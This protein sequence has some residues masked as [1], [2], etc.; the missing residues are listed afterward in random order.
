LKGI[1]RDGNL[2]DSLLAVYKGLLAAKSWI[3]GGAAL[4]LLSD[5][6]YWKL[7]PRPLPSNRWRHSSIL[8]AYCSVQA[9]CSSQATFVLGLPPVL[10]TVRWVG[11][12][13]SAG[14]CV[15]WVLFLGKHGEAFPD[16]KVATVEEL[17]ISNARL[18]DAKRALRDI[19]WLGEQGRSP[20]NTAVDRHTDR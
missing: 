9:L 12:L 1:P 8:I 16:S 7:L 2:L 4:F 11:A 20:A 5:R 10:N 19:T 15:C 18:D 6:I 13:A 3:A 14:A 17:A